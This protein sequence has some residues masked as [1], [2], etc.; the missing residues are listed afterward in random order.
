MFLFID[1]LANNLPVNERFFLW[2]AITLIKNVLAIVV[3]CQLYNSSFKELPVFLSEKLFHLSA[4]TARNYLP[5]QYLTNHIILKYFI[6]YYYILLLI[7]F[8]H[9]NNYIS[10]TLYAIISY[11]YIYD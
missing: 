11:L 1:G 2:K 6:S 7:L 10:S 8:F 4:K 5:T 9:V 3:F